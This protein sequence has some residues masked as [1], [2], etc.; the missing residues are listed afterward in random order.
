MRIMKEEK[1]KK[2]R[3]KRNVKKLKMS[4]IKHGE[5]AHVG[6]LLNHIKAK[7]VELT[8]L[9][10]MI[11]LIV[12]VTGLYFTFTAIQKPK[13]YNT[14]EVGNFSVTFNEVDENLGNVIDLTPLQPMSDFEGEKTKTYQVKIKN[15]VN[16]KQTFQIKLMRDVA[17]VH[18]DGCNKKQLPYQ[19]LHYKIGDGEVQMVDFSKRSPIL[20]TDSLA[21]HEKRTIK[22]RIW[23][24]DTLPKEYLNYHYHGKLSV[25]SVETVE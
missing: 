10:V 5:G 11:C 1:V 8:F 18:E 16:K 12:I 17:M 14:M 15:T 24:V 25:K 20:Y 7:E 6:H 23:V 22:V 9:C 4:D 21:A 19:Y 13:K 2:V 3:K